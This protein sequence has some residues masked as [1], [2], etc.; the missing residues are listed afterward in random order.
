MTSVENRFFN[1]DNVSCLVLIHA[2]FL[3]MSTKSFMPYLP[4]DVSCTGIFSEHSPHMLH[5]AGETSL[6]EL[7]VGTKSRLLGDSA[8]ED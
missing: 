4:H 8:M 6:N 1:L 2:S 7:S 5:Y 3:S